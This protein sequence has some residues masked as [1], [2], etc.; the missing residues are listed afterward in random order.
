MKTSHQESR[1]HPLIILALSFMLGIVG[2]GFVSTTPKVLILITAFFSLLT[3]AALLWRASVAAIIFLCFS[4]VCAG[5]TLASLERR[6][7]ADSL[8]N[9]L[10][11]GIVKES[12]PVEVTGTLRQ[13][14][15]ASP[16]GFYLTLKVENIVWKGKERPAVGTVTLLLPVTGP[17]AEAQYHSLELRYGARI[18]AMTALRRADNFRNPGGASFTEYL[19]RKGFGAAAFVKSP[20][21]IERLNDE[22]VLLPLAW[23]YRWRQQLQQQISSTFEPETAGILNASLLG[24]RYFL[25]HAA[26]E[27]F[28][29]GGTFHV[30][31]IS[32]LHISFIG[33]LV[34]LLARK[35]S[36][37]RL[38]QF[39]FSALVL[40]GYAIAVGAEV[41]VVRAALMFTMM[42][43]AP[44]LSRR[45]ASLNALG[46][47]ALFLLALQPADLF[48]PSFQLTFLS[49]AAIVVF[50]W[51]LLLR[52]SEI[53]LWRPTRATPYPPTCQ[54]WLRALSETL[55]WQEKDW[56]WELTR[57]NYRYKLFKTPLA[58]QL[59]RYHLQK[60]L[61]YG[62]AALLISFCVQVSMLPL[63]VVHF[64]RV[65]IS[66][67]VLNIGVS[68]I[69]AVLIFTGLAA[70][71]IG[72]LST[73]G[74]APFVSLT[75]LLQW[76][77]VHGVDPFVS[78]G[79]AS[80]R[81]PE[82]S[83][84]GAVVYVLFFV[85]LVVLAIGLA[86]WSPL[87][88]PLD[89]LRHS[90]SYSRGRLLLKIALIAQT[91][92]VAVI[93]LHP[94]SSRNSERELRIDFLDVGQGDAALVTMPDGTTLLVDGGGRPKFSRQKS[95]VENKQEFV[96]DARS[97]GDAVVSE[98]LWW[99]GLHRVDYLLA[100]HAD[101]D[102]MEGLNDVARNFEVRA[103]LVAR[104]PA[105]DQEFSEFSRT[106][107]DNDVAL[108][109]I[110]RGDILRFGDVS[111]A[112]LWPPSSNLRPRSSNNDSI[113]LQFQFG[114][115]KILLLG[116][117]ERKAELGLLARESER[118]G[119]AS[120]VV[121]VAHHG[122]RTSSI[123]SF[124]NATRP[125]VAI[126]SVGQR[127]IFGHP[128]MEV[129]SRWHDAGAEILTTGQSGTITVTTDGREM[130]VTK[131]VEE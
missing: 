33:G 127:S 37:R 93:L 56:R 117:I 44:I 92:L 124:V 126:I 6:R 25:S 61:R 26:A 51:P 3:L 77:M 125:R 50:A 43:F 69:M 16:Q 48:D 131:F 1:S 45:A 109:L 15:E 47:A 90:S 75:Y 73:S 24:N 54:R 8:R 11:Q 107:D 113:V 34:L 122:S 19:D 104:T 108:S 10:D 20:Q 116:D 110:G 28:R 101:A 13:Q 22:P 85:P 120:D 65:S 30:L 53:G 31:V 55:F 14:P 80:L 91:I 41:S 63:M 39:L 79:I 97:I 96:R 94:L 68:V 29:E 23:L 118:G 57:L 2:V 4:Y 64:H 66:A 52:L 40:W 129:V 100:T 88:R 74:A 17:I 7:S 59:E 82:Y 106:L 130:K 38:T 119:L 102:H 78:L 115:H 49:V 12:E 83:G 98:Y 123:E 112:V 99:R 62:F 5:A 58:A 114:K 35:I 121:K 89:R 46:A 67:L 111:A 42:A 84:S 72:M 103:A 27:R 18:R 87:A 71:L 81:L 76:L 60:P 9:L 32:G 128:H 70:L 95:E 86:R 36:R 105:N 21:L